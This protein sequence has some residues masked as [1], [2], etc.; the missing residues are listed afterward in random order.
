M[1]DTITEY[2]EDFLSWLEDVQYE[3]EDFFS[4]ENSEILSELSDACSTG[5]IGCVEQLIDTPIEYLLMFVFAIL[6]TLFIILR[7][8]YYIFGDAEI[9]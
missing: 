1:L 4:I 3:I 5:I 2:Y 8:F 7:I 9:W 6:I